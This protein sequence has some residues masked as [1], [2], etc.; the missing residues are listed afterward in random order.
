[1]KR[2]IFSLLTV[3]ILFGILFSSCNDN[4]MEKLR[5]RELELLADFVERYEAEHGVEITPMPSGLYYVE[6]EQGT[7]D[8]ILIGD[9][10][11]VWYNTYLLADTSLVDSNM[12]DGH[13]YNPL[14]FIVNVQNQSTVIEGLNEAVKYMQPGGK[15]FLIVPSQIAYG[16]DGSYGI[17]SFS[18]LLF[19]VEIYK[20][21][22]ASEGY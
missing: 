22:P 16:Q 7:G 17:P 11:Q 10:V 2:Y 9:K 8:T 5:E 18:T 3:L 19:D 1:M 4:D 14:E 6:V 12:E 15:A 20:V 21:Y 13:K